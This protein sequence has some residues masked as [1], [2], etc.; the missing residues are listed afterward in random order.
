MEPY[1][2]LDAAIGWL[3][4]GAVLVLL[5]VILLPGIGFLFAGLAAITVGGMVAFSAIAENATIM[6][7]TW[8]FLLTG[9]W[10]AILWFPM[11]RLRYKTSGKAYKN[12]IGDS[13]IVIGTLTKHAYGQVKWSGTTMKARLVKECHT[14]SLPEG[15]EVEIVSVEGAKLYVKPKRSS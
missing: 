6:Q 13:A 12:M 2:V 15:S 3:L 10:A 14:D 1:F 7:F 8:F 9:F 4:A 11:K 5:E